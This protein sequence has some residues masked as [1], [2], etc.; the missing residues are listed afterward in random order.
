[1]S[2]TLATRHDKTRPSIIKGMEDR[3]WRV[4][5]TGRRKYNKKTSTGQEIR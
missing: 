2:T 4:K 5:G 3:E 1:M